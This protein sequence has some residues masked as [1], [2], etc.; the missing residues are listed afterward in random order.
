[1]LETESNSETNCKVKTAVPMHA[2]GFRAL[3]ITTDPEHML[4]VGK[5]I[6]IIN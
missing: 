1:M 4:L 5:T 3:P 2:M 6:L